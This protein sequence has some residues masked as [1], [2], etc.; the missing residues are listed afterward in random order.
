MLGCVYR[1]TNKAGFDVR[2]GT[3]MVEDGPQRPR[4]DESAGEITLGGR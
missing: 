3:L 1:P 4:D 2:G